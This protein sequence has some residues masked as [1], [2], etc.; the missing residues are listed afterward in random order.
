MVDGRA[1]GSKAAR[2][3]FC[4]CALLLLQHAR[5]C[6]MT[7]CWMSATASRMLDPIFD[8]SD[9]TDSRASVALLR[10]CGR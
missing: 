6:P 4:C 9:W 3:R 5:A 1:D 7:L 2:L 10:V 8:A